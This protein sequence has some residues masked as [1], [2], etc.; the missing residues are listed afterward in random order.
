[1]RSQN[2]SFRD[3]GHADAHQ[4]KFAISLEMSDIHMGVMP[5]NMSLSTS[6]GLVGEK[7]HL[8]LDLKPW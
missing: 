8:L 7:N 1:M 6:S 3:F 5:V 4:H 2:T